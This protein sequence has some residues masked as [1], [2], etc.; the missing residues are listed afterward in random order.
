MPQENK[1]QLHKDHRQRVRTQFLSN[2]IEAMPDHNVLEM[3]LFYSVP[4]RDTNELAHKLIDTFGSLRGV[5]DA[6]ADKLMEVKGVTECTTAMLT[7]MPQLFRRYADA[8]KKKISLLNT[9]EMQAYFIDKFVGCTVERLYMLCFDGAGR[10]NNCC[11][12]NEGT[13]N[14]VALDRRTVLD[15]AF[16]CSAES[17]AFA[18]N[19]P[20]GVAAPSRDDILAT[21]EL[22]SLFSAVDIKVID[23]IIVSGDE[24]CSMA[25]SQRFA[26]LFI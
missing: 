13:L 23:H 7:L 10:V 8:D 26:A 6:P 4:R 22:V 9:D 16:R 24:A 5:L 14:N 11:L 25:K 2:G 15:T 20:N 18:H 1:A 19:H 12:L 3:L 21:Q 17:V